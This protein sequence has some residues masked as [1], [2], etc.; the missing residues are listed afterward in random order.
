M[1]LVCECVCM[2]VCVSVC[3]CMP[4]FTAWTRFACFHCRSPAK[5]ARQSL[6]VDPLSSSWRNFLPDP[7]CNQRHLQCPL[8]QDSSISP[9]TQT[10]MLQHLLGHTL[11]WE[12]CSCEA[13]AHI[14]R[15]HYA[16]A[17]GKCFRATGVSCRLPW[18]HRNPSHHCQRR[19][20]HRQSSQ[21]SAEPGSGLQRLPEIPKK[22]ETFEV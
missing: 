12:K 19:I 5:L 22:S 14:T 11:A 2:C 4:R 15:D 3:V 10:D 20:L 6:A 18:P 17:F 21:S 16:Q 7:A 8:C 1:S 9:E 13:Q